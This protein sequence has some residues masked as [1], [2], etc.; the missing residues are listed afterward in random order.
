MQNIYFLLNFN[1]L[2][3]KNN[4]T[5]TISLYLKKIFLKMI[6]HFRIFLT[7]KITREDMKIYNPII[8]CKNCFMTVQ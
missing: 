1:I 4:E 6:K 7:N 8:L 3:F 2:F 5:Y